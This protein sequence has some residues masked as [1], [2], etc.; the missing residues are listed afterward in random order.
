VSGVNWW[1]QVP[2]VNG[3]RGDPCPSR[4]VWLDPGLATGVIE[5]L[6]EAGEVSTREVSIFDA[7]D[8]LDDCLSMS[9]WLGWEQFVIQPG[10]SRFSQDGSALEVIG[11]ARYWAYRRV[12]RVLYPSVR[13]D[14]SL[15]MKHLKAVGWHTPGHDHANAAAGHLLSWALKSHILPSGLLSRLPREKA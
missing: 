15:G 8:Y 5:W 10:S 14:K 11:V 13:S 2:D 3:K 4:V 1:L 9:A 6:P 7:G 12:A